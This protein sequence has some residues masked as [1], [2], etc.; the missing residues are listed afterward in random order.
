MSTLHGPQ[1]CSI[2]HLKCGH[3][4]SK[5]LK[6]NLLKN[7]FGLLYF[8]KEAP[9]C[10]P[11]LT[12][13]PESSLT[14]ATLIVCCSMASWMEVLSCSRMLLNSSMQQRPPSART[15]APASNCHSPPSWVGI[16]VHMHEIIDLVWFGQHLNCYLLNIR[17]VYVV[18]AALHTSRTSFVVKLP[19]NLFQEYD[20]YIHDMHKFLFNPLLQS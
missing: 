13:V 4:F 9:E 5:H 11:H 20:L 3:H 12:K 8:L 6:N 7:H 10:H 2:Q 14:L 18:G 19:K 16:Y 15:R 1:S 17:V